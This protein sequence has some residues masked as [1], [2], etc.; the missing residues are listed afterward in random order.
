MLSDISPLQFFFSPLLP[1][2]S[3]LTL[4]SHTF[5]LQPVV[6]VQYSISL[7]SSSL[8]L[9]AADGLKAAV[10]HRWPHSGDEPVYPNCKSLVSLCA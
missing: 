10:R 9:D 8:V 4:M 6:Y 7:D 2:L 3:G 5:P 1:P